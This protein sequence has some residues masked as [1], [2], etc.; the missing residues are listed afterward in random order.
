MQFK[1]KTYCYCNRLRFMNDWYLFV[2]EAKAGNFE[3]TWS[4][5]MKF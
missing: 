1:V 2:Q 4:L 3:G 5:T